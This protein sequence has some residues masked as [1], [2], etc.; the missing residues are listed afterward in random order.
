MLMFTSICRTIDMYLG[1]F[2]YD[3]DVSYVHMI[4]NDQSV[5]DIHTAYRVS[6]N[7][8]KSAYEMLIEEM[9]I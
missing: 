4:G 5:R 1:Y 8:I 7:K 2:V 6:L 3:K 9:S